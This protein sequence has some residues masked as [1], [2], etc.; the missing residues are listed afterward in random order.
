MAVATLSDNL[1]GASIPPTRAWK[2]KCIPLQ[3]AHTVPLLWRTT[4]DATQARA[5][6]THTPCMRAWG[7]G[8]PLENLE[9]S[10]PHNLDNRSPYT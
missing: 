4:L 3:R 6:R 9:A 8:S 2:P 7:S 5:P 10:P 1:Q